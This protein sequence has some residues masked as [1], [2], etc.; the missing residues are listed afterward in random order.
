VAG[1]DTGVSV[2]PARL[3]AYM[4]GGWASRVQRSS[5]DSAARSSSAT[6]SERSRAFVDW[7]KPALTD[8][9]GRRVAAPTG[10]RAGPSRTSTW[11]LWG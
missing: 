6:P 7:P 1:S 5:T 9:S 2:V 11:T 4:T 8:T 10:T 3:T